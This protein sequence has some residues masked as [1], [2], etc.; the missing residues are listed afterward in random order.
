[1][2]LQDERTPMVGTE[3][4]VLQS[5]RLIVRPFNMGDLD[6][7]HRILDIDMDFGGATYDERRDWLEWAVRNYQQLARLYQPPYGERAVTLKDGTLIGAVGLVPSGIPWGVLPDC[8][9]PGEPPN[10]FVSAEFGLFWAIGPAHQRQGY[11]SEAAGALIDYIFKT[12]YARRVVAQTDHTNLASQAVM[13]R[14]GMKVYAN[15]G[16]D[17]FWFEVVGVLDNPARR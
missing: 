4:P 1:M 15:P 6:A 8:R 17:P 7:F 9:A 10:T 13:R 14:L 11:A 12:I 16:D 2:I 5:E 3:M